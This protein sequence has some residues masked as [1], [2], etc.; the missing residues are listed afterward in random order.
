[1]DGEA[2]SAKAGSAQNEKQSE[3]NSAGARDARRNIAGEL[4]TDSLA[5]AS[6]APSISIRAKR[7]QDRAMSIDV[8]LSLVRSAP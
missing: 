4:R 1:M 5:A 6:H 7:H 2:G 8:C 3:T